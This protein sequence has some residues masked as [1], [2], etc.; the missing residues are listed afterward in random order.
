MMT[1][2]MLAR[3][4]DGIAAGD[5]AA[6]VA[7]FRECAGA[8]GA[9]EKDQFA[10][11]PLH[12]VCEA[13]S[14]SD[15][16]TLACA[17]AVLE[18]GDE[19]L[20]DAADQWGRTPLHWVSDRGKLETLRYLLGKGPNINAVTKHADTALLWAVKAGRTGA[21]QLMLELAGDGVD[22][23]IKNNRGETAPELCADGPTR[24]MLARALERRR[25]I[26]AAAAAAAAGSSFGV[27]ARQ[28]A[29]SSSSSKDAAA[30][31]EPNAKAFSAYRPAAGAGPADDAAPKKKLKIKLRK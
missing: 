9:A 30:A 20:I 4:R 28:V 6:L 13:E 14:V 17:R 1:G 19:A 15:A 21:V 11:T 23:G 26:D 5:G 7:A 29:V 16:D 27:G 3:V 10:Q 18:M 22:V 31:A 2:T 12:V 24:A 25:E 8:G